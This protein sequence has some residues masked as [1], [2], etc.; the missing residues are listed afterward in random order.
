M[1]GLRQI[2]MQHEIGGAERFERTDHLRIE[3]AA[4]AQHRT[5]ARPQSRQQA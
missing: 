2:G 1:I 5:Q 3:I 4:M